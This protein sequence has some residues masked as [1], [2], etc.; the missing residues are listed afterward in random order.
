MILKG[1][2]LFSMKKGEVGIGTITKHRFPDEG[3]IETNGN[4]VVIRQAIPG[5]TV[6]FVITRKKGSLLKGRVLRVLEQSEL[7]N[8]KNPCEKSGICGGCLYQSLGY[9]NQLKLKEE[10]VVDLL[11]T[12]T[13]DD[14]TW[15]GILAS[16]QIF[17]YRNK[18]EFSFGDEY[19]DGPLA[20]GMHKRGSHYDIVNAMDCNIVH[21]DFGKIL[22]A[23]L[24]FFG[25]KGIR[26]YHKMTHEG[27][28]RHLLIRRSVKKGEL[29]IDLVTTS[30]EER[31]K[32]TEILQEW[33]ALILS[34][35]LEGT[36]C[37]I[38]HTTNN[39]IADAVIDQGTSILYG[40]DFITENL[41]GLEFKI[42]TFSFFQTNSL[43]AEVLYDIAGKY[44]GDTTGKSVFDLYSGTGTI[45][46]LLARVAEQ[47][48][49]VEI[50]EE[51]VYAARDNAMRNGI[52]NCTF[53]AGD[54]LKVVKE[55]E[56]KPDIIV[57]DPPRDG[58]HP[59][60]LPKI[61]DFNANKIVY[62][63]CKPS[64][65][66][67]DLEVLNASGY[68]LVKACAV[69]MFPHTANVETIALLS[70]LDSKRHI[71]IEFP[72]DE[73]DI[74]CA[75]SK[76]TYKQIKNYVLEKYGFKVSTLYIAQVK[77]KHGLEVREH[78]NISKNKNQKV[79]QCPIEKKEAIMDALK[80]F[81]MIRDDF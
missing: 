16:P 32:F 6:E 62:I 13:I 46:Q 2:D 72:L 47:V 23:T 74:T 73:M 44:I 52:D 78:Y 81:K 71:S 39:S 53:I 5:Q 34:L 67:R 8:A 50:V 49:G 64:S 17:G 63:S 60:A 12:A 75:E 48:I 28:L 18:M 80:H 1:V 25:G 31:T 24:E 43:G 37:G 57:L 7:E 45:A 15:E 30:N 70:K 79:P 22:S 11:R 42:S 59:K 41:L 51:A 65:L 76:A 33:K 21:D 38:L 77:K 58:I 19:K 66:A 69:D 4:R 14:F 20:L 35:S 68:H 26:Y 40:Q 9:E 54:V 36:I 55:L 56:V 61:I 10:Q 29:L 3:I 27:V